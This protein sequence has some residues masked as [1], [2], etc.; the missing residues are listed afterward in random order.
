[1][2]SVSKFSLRKIAQLSVLT[3]VSALAACGGGGG[4]GGS[5]DSNSQSN[6]GSR[7]VA[8]TGTVSKGVIR[9]GVVSVYAIEAGTSGRLLASTATNQNGQFTATISGYEGPVYIEVTAATGSTPTLMLCDAAAGCG[10]FA[11][12]SQYDAN[13][14]QVI[15]FGESFQVSNDFLLTTA[16]PTASLGI[17]TSVS[18]LTH[19]AA[20]FAAQM[21][22]GFNDVSIAVAMS[23]VQNLFGLEGSLIGLKAIDL[24][25]PTAV[26]NA[27]SSEL[28]YA[29]LSSSIMGLTNDVAF[30]STLQ[31]LTSAFVGN[32]GQLTQRSDDALVPSFLD[33]VQQALATAQQLNLVTFTSEFQQLVATLQDAELNSLTDSEASPGAG[34]ATAEKVAAFVQDLQLWQGYLSLDPN[35]SSFTQVVSSMGASTGADLTHMLQALAIAGQYGPIVALPDLALT[36]ACDSLANYLARLSCRLLIAGKSLQE[37]CEGTLNLVL[38]GRSL[39]DILNDLTLP[40]GAGVYGHFALYDGVVRIY[41]SIENADVD[42]TFT[43]SSRSSNRY[44]FTVTGTVDT[45]TGS[46]LIDSGSVSLVFNGG[47]D[48][49]NLKLPESASGSIQVHYAQLGTDENPA[50]MQFDGSVTLDLDLR[51]VRS[52]ETQGSYA[53]LDQ[54][55]LALTANGEFSSDLG[56]SFAGSLTINGGIDSNVVVRFET[57]LPDYSDRA[58]ITLTATPAQLADGLADSIRM[59]WG[60]KQYDI[61]NFTGDNTGIRIT[62]QD[63]LI[64]DLDLTVEDGQTAGYLLL[65]GVR[66]GTVSPLN[67]SL[68]FTLAD[69]SETV[70]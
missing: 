52:A 56:E 45:A 61:L 51:N 28:R 22:Q 41:G 30:S 8:L 42:V 46:L 2:Q 15:D 23:Q 38:F 19:L 32:N 67:G 58:V 9:N 6:S 34:G 50:G 64:M 57:D 47:L 1:M 24:T 63:G 10:S 7:S 54:I 70:L 60:G 14:N 53:G 68:L 25:N 48:I 43:R 59:S 39:C 5:Q 12:D 17:A 18:T 37:I 69:G 13:D 16:L 11:A 29:L 44:G 66:F 33:L 36:A 31:A 55:Q 49:R 4:G 21:P 62:N 20:Q 35:Q 26:S 27:T 65:N 3:M 40:L